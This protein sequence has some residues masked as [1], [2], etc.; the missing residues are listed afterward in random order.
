MDY[1]QNRI[2]AGLLC[3]AVILAV[4]DKV[5]SGGPKDNEPNYAAHD[6]ANDPTGD[7]TGEK[8]ARYTF[9]LDV[10]TAM[11]VVATFGLGW[12]SEAQPTC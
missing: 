6:S 3:L 2:I 12:V 11:L 7:L 4:F 10:L 9:G 1:R 5:S 8:L